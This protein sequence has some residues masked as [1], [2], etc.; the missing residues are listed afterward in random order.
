MNWYVHSRYNRIPPLFQVCFSPELQA[1]MFCCSGDGHFSLLSASVALLSSEWN[2]AASVLWVLI[3][4]SLWYYCIERQKPFPSYAHIDSLSFCDLLKE[5][6]RSLLWNAK[7]GALRHLFP[8]TPE[9]QRFKYLRYYL[10]SSGFSIIIWRIFF[11]SPPL[12]FK[13]SQ[14]CTLPL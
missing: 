4:Q 12:I 14:G 8:F 1:T 3:R 6:E 11:T 5:S 9:I 13:F 2:V 10:S 7:W